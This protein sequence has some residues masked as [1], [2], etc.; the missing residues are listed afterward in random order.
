MEKYFC[1]EGKLYAKG[2][3]VKIRD[4]HVEKFKFHLNL[5]FEVYNESND[6]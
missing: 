1:F 2:T 4:E 6:T 5:V 3:I